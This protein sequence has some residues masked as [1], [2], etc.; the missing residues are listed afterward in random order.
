MSFDE[1]PVGG[2][3]APSIDVRILGGV[4]RRVPLAHPFTLRSDSRDLTV[5]YSWLNRESL[6]G[7]TL[8]KL[9]LQL[10]STHSPQYA[11][12]VAYKLKRLFS[13]AIFNQD[14]PVTLDQL[15]HLPDLVPLSFWPFIQ[16]I[17]RKWAALDDC[18]S[19]GDDVKQF[20]AQPNKWEEQ[21]KGAYFA[22]LVNDPDNGAL[23]EQ[24]L[25][26]IQGGLNEAYEE[27]QC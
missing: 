12:T 4:I 18:G 27:G 13:A 19:L 5:D 14:T 9:A 22:L 16:P 25:Q 3:G 7:G 2:Q 15:A 6:W 21:G 10:L 17:M 23:T 24:E 8:L 11:G 1:L 26:S 20:L